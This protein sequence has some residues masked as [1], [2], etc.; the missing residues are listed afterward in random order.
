MGPK[1]FAEDGFQGIRIDH[2]HVGFGDR[3]GHALSQIVWQNI[4]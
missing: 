3:S 4:I 1:I 2:K